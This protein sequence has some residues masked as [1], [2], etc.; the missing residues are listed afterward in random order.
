[1]TNHQPGCAS[2]WMKPGVEPGPGGVKFASAGFVLMSCTR[3]DVTP[4]RAPEAKEPVLAAPFE[5][6][7]P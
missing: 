5:A 2:N 4:D 6:K 7:E 1:M 3:P